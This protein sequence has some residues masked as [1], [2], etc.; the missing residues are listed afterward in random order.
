MKKS[1]ESYERI[2]CQICNRICYNKKDLKI[3]LKKE[4]PELP[5]PQT[6]T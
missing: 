6:R 1:D 3:H 2:I 5:S 4:H